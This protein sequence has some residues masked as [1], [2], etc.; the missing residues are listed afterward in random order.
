M[1]FEY[2]APSAQLSGLVA[3]HYALETGAEGVDAGL[4]ALLGQVQ[5]LVGGGA[6]YRFGRR[7]SRA[8]AGAALIGPTDSAGVLRAPPGVTAIGCGLT[9]AGWHA[10]T[11]G[12]AL[13][14]AAVALP[15]PDAQP[16]AARCAR[17]GDTAAMAATLDGYLVARL[18]GVAP[19]PRIA[20]IDAWIIAGDGWDID[21]LAARLGRSRRSVE[22]LTVATH[23]ATPKRLAAKYRSLQAAARLA[24]GDVVDWHDAVAI[25]GFVDQPHFIREFTR[26]IG[27]TP[28]AFMADPTRFVHQLVRGQWVPGR[29]LGI[30]IFG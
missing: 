5:L 30:A 22:R 24:V 19:D 8:A 1:R 16:L 15:L 18:G 17:A 26:F 2:F 28:G 23:G 25:G 6:E 29:A 4:C 13:A 14:N 21:T 10:L 27:V 9:P 7:I 12:L 11:G 20:I 3:F